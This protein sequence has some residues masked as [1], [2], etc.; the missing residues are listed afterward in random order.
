MMYLA[1]SFALNTTYRKKP[2]LPDNLNFPNESRALMIYIL[3]EYNVM[4]LKTFF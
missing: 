2:K 4:Y 1:N 3:M